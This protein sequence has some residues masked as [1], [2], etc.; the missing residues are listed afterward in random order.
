VP[1]HQHGRTSADKLN[2]GVQPIRHAA[3]R[4]RQ[5][6]DLLYGRRIL[7]PQTTLIVAIQCHRQADGR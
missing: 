5:R 6:A 1:Q 3:Y 7:Q 2:G 4:A